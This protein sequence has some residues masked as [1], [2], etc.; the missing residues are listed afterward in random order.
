MMT[1]SSWR[2]TG[3]EDE[4]LEL[5]LALSASLAVSGRSGSVGA[6]QQQ[7]SASGRQVPRPDGLPSILPQQRTPPATSQPHVPRR[8]SNATTSKPWTQ[9]PQSYPIQPPPMAQQ[10]QPLPPQQQQPFQQQHFQQRPQAPASGG[11]D[12]CPGCSSNIS[13]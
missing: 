10:R 8:G 6:Q 9:N 12:I 4:E 11:P 5:A 2:T 1:S 7:E 3:S 13:W